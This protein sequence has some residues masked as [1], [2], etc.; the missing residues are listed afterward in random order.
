MTSQLRKDHISGR[1]V[2]IAAERSKRPDDFRPGRPDERKPPRSGGFCPFCPGNEAKTPAE[3]YAVRGAGSAPATS[4]WKVRVVPNKFPALSR[5]EPPLRERQGIF[6]FMEGV[7]DHEVVIETPDHDRDMGDWPASHLAEVLDTYRQRLRALES[8]PAAKYIQLFKNKGPEAGAS[9]GHPHAQ[10]VAMPI[11]P[12]QIKEEI[13]SA[14]RFHARTGECIFCRTILEE[15]AAA[16]RLVLANGQFCVFA[17]FASRFPFEMRI[18]PLRHGPAFSAVRDE[19]LAGLSEILK[20]ALTRLKSAAADP[21]YN[22]VLHQSPQPG[23]A[24]KTWPQ[25]DALFHWYLE[26]LPVL[27]HVAGFEWGTGYY[28][29]PVSPEDAARFLREGPGANFL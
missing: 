24:S 1:W 28:I 11:I 10:I 19:E 29:N 18:V 15:R 5:G 2:I 20:A 27:T 26:I 25:I 17:P 13:Y 6:E 22:L 23:Q 21:P 14:E 12:R 16:A 8:E 7:G 3:I 4:G 9:L